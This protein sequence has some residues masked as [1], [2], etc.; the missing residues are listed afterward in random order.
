MLGCT[1]LAGDARLKVILQF[2]HLTP[3]S[4]HMTIADVCTAQ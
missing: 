4:V 3:C 2:D 1:V